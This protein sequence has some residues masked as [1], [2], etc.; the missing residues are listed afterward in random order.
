MLEKE[1]TQKKCVPCRGGIPPM[2]PEKAKDYIAATPGW[3]LSDDADRISRRFEFATFPKAIDFVVQVAELAEEEGHHPDFAIHYNKV[4][5]LL[6][7]HKINGLHENDFIMA[8]KINGL[9]G[10]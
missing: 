9:A 6:W 8:A 4:D 3:S 1:L 10:R 2:K 5:I 7:T